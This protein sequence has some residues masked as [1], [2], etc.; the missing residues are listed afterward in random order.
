MF[1]KEELLNLYDMNLNDL[2]SIA[3]NITNEN[4]N[5]EVEICSIIS[6]VKIVNTVLK[7]FITTQIYFVTRFW[8]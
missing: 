2:V 8:I 6:A 1:K 3:E 4:F 7:V 5:N